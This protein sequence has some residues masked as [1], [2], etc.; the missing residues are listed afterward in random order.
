[1]LHARMALQC[2]GLQESHTHRSYRGGEHF[3]NY[4]RRLLQSD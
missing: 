1:M 2:S 3:D 4:C